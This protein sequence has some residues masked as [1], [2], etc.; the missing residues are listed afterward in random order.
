MAEELTKLQIDEDTRLITLDI[1]DM[2][3]NLPTTGIILATE[4]W[5]N[6]QHNSNKEFNQQITCVLNAII[7]QNYFQHEG[8]Y[9][10]PRHSNGI[11]YIGL[12]RGN[13]PAKN[14]KSSQ[15]TLAGK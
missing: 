10:K 6:K 14:R 9:Y 8:T 15:K 13:I 1:K 11:T 4:F 2:Y 5:L 7:K 12:S 3:V